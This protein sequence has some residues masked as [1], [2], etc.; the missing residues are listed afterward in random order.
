MKNMQISD[1]LDLLH[2]KGYLLSSAYEYEENGPWQVGIRKK[3]LFVSE[4]HYNTGDTLVLAILNAIRNRELEPSTLS[5]D[6][7]LEDF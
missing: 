7:I 2:T 5:I 4:V 3:G 6:D 1:V